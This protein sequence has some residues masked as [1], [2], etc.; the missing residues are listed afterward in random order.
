MRTESA[1]KDHGDEFTDHLF[2]MGIISLAEERKQYYLL[3]IFTHSI[4][5][6]LS[7][8]P[9]PTL[10][11]PPPPAPALPTPPPLPSQQEQY[12]LRTVCNVSRNVKE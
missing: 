5:R 12:E 11:P 10:T 7:T 2:T 8:P 9:T 3:N 4:L 6:P 1:D